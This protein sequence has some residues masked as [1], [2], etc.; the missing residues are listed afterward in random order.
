M[1]QGC[2]ERVFS[3]D[4]I[5]W[6]LAAACDH[7]WTPLPG[8]AQGRDE[9][10]GHSDG[11][12]TAP[13]PAGQP[14]QG[15]M[16]HNCQALPKPQPCLPKPCVTCDGSRADDFVHHTQPGSEEEW[17]TE[18]HAEQHATSSPAQHARPMPRAA[19]DRRQKQTVITQ[20]S[21][22]QHAAAAADSAAGQSPES[23][24]VDHGHLG[25]L[26]LAGEAHPGQQTAAAAKLAPGHL[27]ESSL[28]AILM[29]NDDMHLL[30]PG[31]LCQAPP[32]NL[33]HI[34]A[35]SVLLVATLVLPEARACMAYEKTL[36][37]WQGV[38][39]AT[40]LPLHV[41]TFT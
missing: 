41:L 25:Q 8:D 29:E 31:A 37:I 1:L 4:F 11:D 28:L 40:L 22:G 30:E 27:D 32:S 10:A 23:C 16:P 36:V 5:A 6:L 33:R 13:Q 26:L 7:L 9:T 12:G 2:K 24:L 38:H 17:A 19:K 20:P 3:Q 21:P 18:S 14:P 34:G 39:T 15:A 35:E